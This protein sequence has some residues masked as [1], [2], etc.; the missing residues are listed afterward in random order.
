M[1]PPRIL[2]GIILLFLVSL[3]SAAVPACT[4]LT[5]SGGAMPTFVKN[6]G[7][8]TVTAS[9]CGADDANVTVKLG[10]LDF[11][12]T[13]TNIV[14]L[15]SSGGGNYNT[16]YVI[17]A[18]NSNADGNK[19]IDLNGACNSEGCQALPLPSANI[20]LDNTKPSISSLAVV[21]PK[22]VTFTLTDSGSNINLSL[23]RVDING[24]VSTSFA[25]ASNC[26]I[27]GGAYVCSY[28]E[29]AFT[30]SGSDYNV[31]VF[32]S[33]NLG[34]AS[35]SATV[36]R[37]SDSGAP[38]QVTGL[39]ATAGDGQVVLNWSA[40]SESD[41][42]HYNVYMS[43]TTGFTTDSS[44]KIAFVAKGTNTYTKTG[45][46]NG[47]QYFFRV[48]A[49][50]AS[51]NE[52]TDS[53]EKSATP[54]SGSALSV[55]ISSS[56][57][58]DESKWYSDKTADLTWGSVSG[59]TYYYKY[60]STSDSS[61]SASDNDGSTASTSF[62][63]AQKENGTWY[64]HLVACT[65]STSCGSTDH[66]TIKIDADGP[67]QPQDFTV[68]TN[69]SGNVEID[70]TAP[71]DN[72]SSGN[73][74]V[75]EYKVYRK[76]NDDLPN[77]SDSIA[78]T[79]DTFF[80]DD[81][82]SLNN[83]VRYY[84]WV[85][86][87]DNASNQGSITGAKSVL[88]S[89]NSETCSID[90]SESIPSFVKTG[91]LSV[92][93][94]SDED[95]FSPRIRARAVGAGFLTESSINYGSR[96]AEGTFIVDS[97]LE[98][99]T[100]E[101]TLTASDS[102]STSCSYRK[103]VV[104][105]ETAPEIEW[106]LPLEGNEIDVSEPLRIS[107]KAT[108][109][110]S[111]VQK[112]VFYFKQNGSFEKI[113]EDTT[114]S[115]NEFSVSFSPSNP[116]T[117]EIEFKAESFD[118]AGNTSEKTVKTNAKSIPGGETVYDSKEFEFEAS[119]LEEMLKESGLEQKLISNA[120]EFI[121]NNSV[122]RELKI[123][124][125]GDDFFARVFVEFSNDSGNAVDIKIVEVVPKDFAQSASMLSSEKNF[126]VLNDDPVIEFSFTG[127]QPGEKI[128]LEYSLKNALTK[129]QADVLIEKNPVQMFS[130][131]PIVLEENA[132]LSKSFL[133]QKP[134]EIDLLLV[135]IIVIV[136]VLIVFIGLAVFGGGLV[137]HLH[138]KSKREAPHSMASKLKSKGSG[139][140][141]RASKQLKDWF[142]QKE[143][144]EKT[145]GRFKW[146]GI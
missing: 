45:L 71:A 74:G 72:P 121:E 95:M 44:T 81:D 35:Q 126:T 93:I 26:T 54:V 111:G 42:N 98:G 6:T 117:G 1:K 41:L 70:W 64:F 86:A 37:Y 91:D 18:G 73:S 101:I 62:T 99:K 51:E 63:A 131:P 115:N 89:K 3:A 97:A 94:T 8:I 127:V 141:E 23:A 83:G 100:I 123:I 49:L 88:I 103:N 40:N 56:S 33:D 137:F 85:R 20:F 60:N 38:S 12:A 76:L 108:D 27:A 78:T 15:N 11:N 2:I 22:T 5:V 55:T 79:T 50:D 145:G 113:G 69:S 84:Y 135:L 122:K 124:Q 80:T 129:T 25:P 128:E 90:F 82:S 14:K 4:S 125:A 96:F 21:A 110:K 133:G 65:N 46:T 107:V 119:S 146:K 120:K 16:T 31:T 53:D 142:D 28:T 106:V 24:S 29:N 139:P 17:G 59:A 138:R 136:I 10:T 116:K 39:T 134:F 112:V 61:V 130:A 57:H 9:G 68:T 7:T 102:D 30:T 87:I 105:D 34:N 52:G 43:T 114:A 47:T 132:D 36:F 144:E 140:M 48:S 13:G 118:K 66:Y 19:T 77:D 92:R 67:A 109:E 58:P 75:K 32:A 104:V 143:K